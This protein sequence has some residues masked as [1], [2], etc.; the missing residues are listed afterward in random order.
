[1]TV[2]FLFLFSPNNSGSTIIG[3][4]IAQQTGGYLPP[5][6]NYE[7]QMVP[8]VRPEM[9][10]TDRWNPERE[11]GW[12]RIRKI[13]TELAEEAGK[14]L[15]VE[16]S[17]P[18]I[19]RVDS[20][21]SAFGPESEHLFSISGPY[22]FIAS[23]I[24]NYYQTPVT[25]EMLRIE[26]LNWIERAE[27]M[28]TFLTANPESPRIRYEDFCDDPAV[29]N[30]ALGLAV[31]PRSKLNGKWND[32]IQQVIDLSHR[33]HAFLV[34]AEWEEVNEILR[35]HESLLRFFGYEVIRGQDLVRNSA[36][37]PEL[38]HAGIIR[39]AQWEAQSVAKG[40]RVVQK[41]AA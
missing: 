32:P 29:V 22:S 34:F 28:R 10:T 15:F 7:G 18:N 27:A 6:G 16:C 31:K 14:D 17:P 41:P 1:M 11:M 9:R 36:A 20:I 21:L 39:R 3:Q 33:Q 26:T 13:W 23:T 37:H 38:F 8:L 24:F 40:A 4:Y 30:R 19:M 25:S 5:F 12:P 2:N 35:E